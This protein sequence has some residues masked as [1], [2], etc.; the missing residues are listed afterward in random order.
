MG[1][2][3]LAFLTLAP[4]FVNHARA[5]DSNIPYRADDAGLGMQAGLA[6]GAVVIIL[7]LA[8]VGMILLRKRLAGRL[9]GAFIAGAG[10]RS[11]ASLRL[12]QQTLVHVVVYR[13]REYLFAQC[14]AKLLRLGEFAA[15]A[16]NTDRGA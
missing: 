12:P 4:V 1:W 6:Y 7:A 3:S 15:D 9:P 16:D 13:D 2:R 11:V 10:L 8:V 14:G 5:S